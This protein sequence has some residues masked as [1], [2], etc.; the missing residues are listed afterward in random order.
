MTKPTPYP[1]VLMCLADM[2]RTQSRNSQEQWAKD[3]IAK[4]EKGKK[5]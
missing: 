2:E 5:Q 3:E 4:A 1:V